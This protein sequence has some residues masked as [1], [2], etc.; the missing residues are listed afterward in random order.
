MA[1]LAKYAY[2][3]SLSE[4]HVANP[5]FTLRGKVQPLVHYLTGIDVH[6]ST[7]HGRCG[8]CRCDAKLFHAREEERQGAT[9]TRL[10]AECLVEKLSAW[11]SGNL[12]KLQEELAWI[13]AEQ[14]STA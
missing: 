9:A 8:K 6:E 14:A 4:A 11:L 2:S 12:E 5:V 1:V 13:Q 7:D 10:C 3:P